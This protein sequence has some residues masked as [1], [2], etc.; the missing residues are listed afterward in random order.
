MANKF[1][2]KL[3]YGRTGV[4]Y[5][6]V[7]IGAE[8]PASGLFISGGDF[9]LDDGAAF[10]SSRPIVSGDSQVALLSDIT[11]NYYLSSNPSGFITSL[12]TS[13]LYTNDNPSGFITSNSTLVSGASSLSNVIRITQAGYNAIST[14]L[15]G[16]L[17]II[18]G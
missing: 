7:G 12:D 5:D 6:A 2:T 1:R 9:K 8:A 16:T 14:P 3:L 11:G 18:V 4:F 15:S 17:Y 10:F 13:N